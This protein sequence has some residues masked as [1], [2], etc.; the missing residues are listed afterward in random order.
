MLIYPVPM[1][2]VQ[3]DQKVWEIQNRNKGRRCKLEKSSELP[4]EMIIQDIHTRGRC[5]G[6]GRAEKVLSRSDRNLQ[7]IEQLMAFVV[8]LFPIS[9]K[10]SAFFCCTCACSTP[11]T[12][13]VMVSFAVGTK[14]SVYLQFLSSKAGRC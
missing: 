10:T 6:V 4:C 8:S 1:S 5:L 2:R 3:T 11:L 12:K 7:C 14:G 9:G 13:Q